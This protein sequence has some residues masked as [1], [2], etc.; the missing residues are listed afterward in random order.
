MSRSDLSPGWALGFGALSGYA[1]WASI[2]PLDVIK[3]KLQTDSLNK[4]Q[5]A[6]KGIIDC[7]QKT[8]RTQ[9]VKGFT[10]GLGPTLVR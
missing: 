2:Y 8:W 10:N 3:S 7:A 9:G 5:Q 4:S 6:Y 1:L